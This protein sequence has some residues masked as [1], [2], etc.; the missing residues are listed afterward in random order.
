MEPGKT[1]SELKVFCISEVHALTQLI[2][3][4]AWVCRKIMDRPKPPETVTV[5]IGN[6]IQTPLKYDIA[7]ETVGIPKG[8]HR[9]PTHPFMGQ[10]L[11][12]GCT[13]GTYTPPTINSELTPEAKKD[14]WCPRSDFWGPFMWYLFK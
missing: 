11:V 2:S 3:C 12:S 8:N 5:I 7:P 14:H 13:C 9:L 1:S 6:K 10:A 4:E